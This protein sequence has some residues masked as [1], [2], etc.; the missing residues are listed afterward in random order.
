MAPARVRGAAAIA[1]AVAASASCAAGAAGPEQVHLMVTG[2]ETEMHVSWAE[3]GACST[4]GTVTYGPSATNATGAAGAAAGAAAGTPAPLRAT[5]DA[6]GYLYKTGMTTPI[7]LWDATM[8]GLTRNALYD[9]TLSNSA[10]AP[11]GDVT[12]TFTAPPD[13]GRRGGK[14]YAVYADLGMTNDVSMAQI[15]AEAKAGVYDMV[16]HPGV[17]RAAT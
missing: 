5:V 8:T 7:C 4:S 2:V 3:V 14:V 6:S 16:I 17:R 10:S 13:D 11:G 9:Y 12:F 15:T 1:V